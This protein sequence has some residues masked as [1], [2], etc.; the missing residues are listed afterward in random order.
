MTPWYW[1]YLAVGSGEGTREMSVGVSGADLWKMFDVK[2]V[3]GR[4]FTEQEDLPPDGTHVT[5]ISYAF[6]QTEFGGR[7]DALGCDD[8]HRPGRST[9]SSASRQRASR[10]SA[11]NRLSHSSRSPRTAAASSVA[12][13]FRGTRPTP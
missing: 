4:F 13:A 1:N 2:P 12:E 10:R 7:A 11:P 8:R 9:R 6:W 5:V 3:I